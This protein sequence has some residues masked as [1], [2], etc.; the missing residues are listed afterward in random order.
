MDYQAEK[1]KLIQ[2]I[3]NEKIP[4]ERFLSYSKKSCPDVPPNILARWKDKFYNSD[5]KIQ[6][7]NHPK[8]INRFK[9]G[10][11]PE[12]ILASNAGTGWSSISA[13]ESGLKLKEAFGCD[14]SGRQAEMRAHP[15][16]FVLETVASLVDT[17]RWQMRITDTGKYQW[18][19][20]GAWNDDGCGGHI[21]FGTK[22]VWK[23]VS[24][25]TAAP[26]K[27]VDNAT[28]F[29]EIMNVIDKTGANTRRVHTGYGR[30][31]DVRQQSHGYEYRSIASW[32]FSPRCAYLALVITKLSMYHP[33]VECAT[34]YNSEQATSL[35]ITN[36][37]RAYQ[38]SDDDARI[39][40]KSVEAFGVPHYEGLVDIKP[41]WGVPTIA[42]LQATKEDRIAKPIG[43]KIINM[44][45]PSDRSRMYIP[46]TIPPEEKTKQELFD[47]LVNG[48]DLPRRFPIQ[49]TWEPF[50]LPDGVNVLS[51]P[52]GYGVDNVAE[53]LFSYRYRVELSRNGRTAG[54][55]YC[56]TVPGNWFDDETFNLWNKRLLEKHIRLT[57][58]EVKTPDAFLSIDLPS[59]L[60]GRNGNLH[61]ERV[62]LIRAFL[63]E[64]GT[65]P[66]FKGE[67]YKTFRTQKF[68]VCPVSGKKSLEVKP[69]GRIIQVLEGGQ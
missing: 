15:S 38:G 35:A 10:A 6:L 63:T 39:A 14:G 54:N 13:R 68:E 3:V 30:W 53:G 56:L 18:L 5:P 57:L 51:Y 23:P 26:W 24:K 22:R 55:M 4:Q 46:G 20:P 59:N 62:Q 8:L 58:G 25:I 2:E 34:A 41:Q 67:N 21:H 65:L 33:L 7:P 60:L 11:D 27:S 69:L 52:A 43:D 61:T 37:L 12:Y 32:L 40:L 47:L 48:R 9:I 19:A 42:Q 49:P 36:L 50:A 1:R 64:S 28:K 29:L 17:F 16:K 44:L 66:I 45:M 31:G